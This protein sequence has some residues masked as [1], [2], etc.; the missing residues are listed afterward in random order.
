[1]KKIK[2]YEVK[3]KIAKDDFDTM[4]AKTLA[5]DEKKLKEFRELIVKDFNETRDNAAFLRNLKI[6]AM[7]QGKVP[8]LAKKTKVN[9]AT[10]YRMLSKNSNPLFYSVTSLAHNLGFDFYIKRT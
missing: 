3:C 7:A 5:K 8:A 9:R 10:I 1:M 2:K 4:F 6:F